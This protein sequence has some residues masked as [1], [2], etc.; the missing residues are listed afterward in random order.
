M[1][2]FKYVVKV[3]ND[4]EHDPHYVPYYVFGN[5]AKFIELIFQKSIFIYIDVT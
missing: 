4:L 5:Y 3:I 2:M 1:L